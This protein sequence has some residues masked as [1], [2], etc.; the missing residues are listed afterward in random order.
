MRAYRFVLLDKKEFDTTEPP[1]GFYSDL[2]LLNP[3]K[4]FI[5]EKKLY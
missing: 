1:K 5:Q 4:D 3:L 2:T